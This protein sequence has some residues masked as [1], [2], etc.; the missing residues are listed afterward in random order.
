MN[1][2]ELL[3]VLVMAL[4]FILCGCVIIVYSKM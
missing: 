3:I 1:N 2:D 4:F